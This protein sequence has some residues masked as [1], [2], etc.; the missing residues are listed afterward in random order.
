MADVVPPSPDKARVSAAVALGWQVAKLYHSPVRKGPVTD[1]LQNGRLPGFSGFSA[2]THSDWLGEQIAMTAARLVAAP[3][4]PLLDAVDL[5]LE[6]LKTEN[7]DR[8]ATLGAVFTLHCRL[9][10]ALTVTDFR[11]GKAYG[12]GRALAE[13]TLVPAVPADGAEGK[14]RELLG[15][16][17][18]STV[19]DWLVELKTMLP[20]H[21]AYAVSRGLDDWR[22]WAARSSRS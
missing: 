9:L 5:V 15:A 14:F 1:P 6:C 3:P 7:R 19:K 20:D 16:G 12:L 21:A 8:D 4:Q 22:A 17:R 10:E 18:V 2:A 11:L 13:T